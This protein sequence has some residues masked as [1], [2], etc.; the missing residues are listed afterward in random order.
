MNIK[1]LLQ[2]PDDKNPD[3]TISK[4]QNPNTHYLDT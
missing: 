2:N 4:I 1:D 3:I